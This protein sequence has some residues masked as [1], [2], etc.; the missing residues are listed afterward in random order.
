M[1]WWLFLGRGEILLITTYYLNVLQQVSTIFRIRKHST[2]EKK[3]IRRINRK[4]L[5]INVQIKTVK[6]PEGN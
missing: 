5:R 1:I 2:L 4:H 6:L 3:E